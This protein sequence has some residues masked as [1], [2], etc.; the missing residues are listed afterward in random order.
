M[1]KWIL[2]QLTVTHAHVPHTDWGLQKDQSVLVITV[3]NGPEGQLG[4]ANY[5]FST[6]VIFLSNSY[7]RSTQTSLPSP[8]VENYPSLPTLTNIQA[9]TGTHRHT[10]THTLK[11]SSLQ[12]EKWGSVF[13]DGWIL[14]RSCVV[15][16]AKLPHIRTVLMCRV[17][18]D[19][20]PIPLTPATLY[21]LSMLTSHISH[22]Q[23]LQ[24]LTNWLPQGVHILNT[25]FYRFC[26]IY[27]LDSSPL[28]AVSNRH[29]APMA[30]TTL[31]CQGALIFISCSAFLFLW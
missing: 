14:C 20:Y 6:E 25:T 5:L 29:S 12:E 17:H 23:Q 21:D 19:Q 22:S 24:F 13:C 2:S 30:S 27:W 28:M 15:L 1:Q 31:R 11:D 16:K 10:L 18:T 26:H 4:A 9:E 3:Y 8:G 7:S